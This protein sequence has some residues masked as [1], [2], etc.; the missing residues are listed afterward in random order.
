MNEV[1]M[2]Y[3]NRAFRWARK[4]ST[5]LFLLVLSGS[6]FAAEAEEFYVAN[7]ESLVQAKCIACHR[8]GGVGSQ[9]L[10]FSGSPTANHQAFDAYVNSPTNGAKA[11]TVLSKISGG[12][13][14]GG[15]VQVAQGSADYAVFSDYMDLLSAATV[16]T[17]TVESSASTGGSIN[18]SGSVD[19]T[20]NDTTSFTMTPS[21][22]YELDSVGGTCGG[23][24]LGAT[25][26]TSAVV[27]NCTVT[28]TF[29]LTTYTVESSAST[30]GSINP[31]GSVDVT[32]NDTTSFT[33]TPSEGYELDSVGGTCGGSLLGATYTTSAVVDNCTVTAT[34]SEIATEDPAGATAFVERFYVNI[35]GRPS[36]EAGLEGWLNVINTQSASAVAFGFLE[37]DEF[38]S[39]NLDDAGFVDILY[40][41]LFDRPGDA[42]G[43]A[44]WLDQLASGRLRE[45]VI[46]QFTRSQEFDTLAKSFGVVAVNSD[47][48]SAYGVRA[49][50]ERF[51]TL[52]LGRQP[53]IAG[54]DNWVAGLTAGTLTGGD[55]AKNF[56]LSEEYLNQDT[57]DSAFVDTCYQAFFGRDA[58][59]AGKQGWLSMLSQGGSRAEVLDG[60]IGSAEFVQLAASFGI[61]AF[62]GGMF[63]GGVSESEVVAR[64]SAEANAIPTVST[65]SLFLMASCLVGLSAVRL[66]VRA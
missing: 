33:V 21:E 46:Y 65:I 13:P 3:R 42:A 54:F 17:Y 31:S 15:G 34:F 22:G 56:F 7:V 10:I 8:A 40:R 20:A 36:D 24:L 52:V 57:S 18:P 25:Y 29:G 58:D 59:V 63:A 6:L 23:S 55:L 62:R 30:G 39:L 47:D 1:D 41:T 44:V 61:K 45:M 16:T 11:S 66:R 9:N 26:T 5:G 48:E 4:C 19:V 51:Y 60:F 43:T 32:A 27:N 35:L 64:V 2:D 38:V 14:H 37:S 28:A 12:M 53:D 49:F 50:T